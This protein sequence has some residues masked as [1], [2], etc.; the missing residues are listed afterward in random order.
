MRTIIAGSRTGVGI[1]DVEA[2]IQTCP[3]LITTVLCGMARGAD[4]CGWFIAV[5]R[6][7]KIEEYPAD[8][9]T[10]G[11]RAGLLRNEEM[12]SKAEALIAV[13]NGVS[14]GTAHMIATAVKAG[15]LVHIHKV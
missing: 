9:K 1:E 11:N 2:A 14:K 13:W 5:R 4:M 12:A 8:W 6:G 10:H 15:L 3:F 7:W